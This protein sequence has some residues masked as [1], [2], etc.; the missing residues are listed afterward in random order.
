MSPGVRCRHFVTSMGMPHGHPSQPDS[1]LA[2]CPLFQSH[3]PPHHPLTPPSHTTPSLIVIRAT[4]RGSDKGRDGKELL[5]PAV[6]ACLVVYLPCASPSLALSGPFLCNPKQESNTNTFETSLHI[7]IDCTGIFFHLFLSCYRFLCFLR[8]FRR[9]AL[10][11]SL[12]V[13]RPLPVT[14]YGSITE[15]PR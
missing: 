15:A 1:I 3:H 13:P 5:I 8:C 14:I 10:S 9:S 12:S 7:I 4:Q 2:A 11:L 6:D